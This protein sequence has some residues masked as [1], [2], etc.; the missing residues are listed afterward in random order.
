MNENTELARLKAELENTWRIASELG[1]ETP[2]AIKAFELVFLEMKFEAE[3]QLALFAAHSVQQ[4]Q[5]T[6]NPFHIDRAVVACAEAGVEPSPTLQKEIA[7][8]AKR[9]VKGEVG[10]GTSKELAVKA[11]KEAALLLIANLIH[12]SKDLSEACS[13]A[14]VWHRAAYP[15][16]KPKK[17]STLEKYYVAEYRSTQGN[18]PSKEQRMF[19]G[20][21]DKEGG[22][23]SN[24]WD[25]LKDD[26]VK[27]QWNHIAKAIPEADATLKGERR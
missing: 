15:D 16:L 23:L 22:V 19:H 7:E 13:K 27:A 26:A 1:D 21:R 25:M 11:A 9:R 3:F 24:G 2:D 4:W 14:A 6:R 8:V 12:S 18:K 10:A 20:R 5:I 17:A